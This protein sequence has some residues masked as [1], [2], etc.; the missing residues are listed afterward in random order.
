LCTLD[1]KGLTSPSRQKQVIP[2]Q[3]QHGTRSRLFARASRAAEF[4]EFGARIIPLKPEYKKPVPKNWADPE[5]WP[6]ARP[7]TVRRWFSAGGRYEGYNYGV[8]GGQLETGRYAGWNL[9][10]IDL[11]CKTDDG[12][13][14][15]TDLCAEHEPSGGWPVTFTVTTPSGGAH[16][17]FVTQAQLGNSSGSLPAGI[18]IRGEGGQVVGPGSW[19]REDKRARQCEGYYDIEYDDP[20]AELPRWI[21]DLIGQ[22]KPGAK[23][24]QAAG[25]EARDLIIKYRLMTPVHLKNSIEGLVGKLDREPPG[26]RNPC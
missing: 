9:I 14:A 6:H 16:L 2:M 21:E 24:G 20:V 23:G 13:G 22:P 5:A 10:I 8:C 11:D 7:R 1:A 26:N 18:D 19:T 4:A 12:L 25:E 17:Y 3:H 15:F